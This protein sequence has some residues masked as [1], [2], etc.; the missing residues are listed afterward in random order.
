MCRTRSDAGP[1]DLAPVEPDHRKAVFLFAVYGIAA[2][3]FAGCF[4]TMI[5]GVTSSS[6]ADARHLIGGSNADQRSTVDAP[7]LADNCV[8]FIRR[9]EP[10]VDDSFF[11]LIKQRQTDAISDA[12]Q[13][14][15]RG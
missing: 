13:T 8:N 10:I 4:R 1:V 9:R 11:H 2:A 6:T 12:D 14:H 15:R 5:E 7:Q 3:G